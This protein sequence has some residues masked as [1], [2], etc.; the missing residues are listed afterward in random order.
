MSGVG[1]V[2]YCETTNILM[3]DEHK[4]REIL[5]QG[6]EKFKFKWE[7]SL[8]NVVADFPIKGLY[9]FEMS[10][11]KENYFSAFNKNY[12][13]MITYEKGTLYMTSISFNGAVAISA[14]CD[15][16]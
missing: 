15:K 12:G 14:K 11:A 9:T 7:K 10:N 3:I 5:K 2:Y 1:D 4:F 6:T 16:F 8:I 13:G